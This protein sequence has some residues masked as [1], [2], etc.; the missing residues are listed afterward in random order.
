MVALLAENSFNSFNFF[1]FFNYLKKTARATARAVL[2]I[3]NSGI[4]RTNHCIFTVKFL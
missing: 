4:K 1:N 3:K 2:F